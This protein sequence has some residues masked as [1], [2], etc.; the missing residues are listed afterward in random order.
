MGTICKMLENAGYDWLAIA[1]R[2]QPGFE[3]CD[4]TVVMPDDNATQ[5]GNIVF[6]QY[7]MVGMS[8][9][10]ESQLQDQIF[11]LE[12]LALFGQYTIWSAKPNVGKTLI[13]LSQLIDKLRQGDIEGSKVFYFDL[14]DNLRGFFE[15]L[16]IAEEFKFRIIGEG[17]RGFKVENFKRDIEKLCKA[18]QAQGVVLIFDTMKMF[19]DLMDKRSITNWNKMIRKFGAKGGT[20]IGLVHTNKKRGADGKLIHAGT[21]D[22]IDDVDCAYII[23]EVRVDHD[24]KIKIVEFEN[25]KDRGDVVKKATFQY[26]IEDGIGYAELLASV[27]R[28][29]PE[30]AE[31]ARQTQDIENDAP[32]IEAIEACIAEDIVTKMALRDEVNKRT[33]ISKTKVVVILDKYTGTDPE[34]YRWKVTTKAH[35][36]KVHEL[37][38]K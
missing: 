19:A 30:F 28:V 5:R 29:G 17:H 15:K 26:S 10:I 6:D 22:V 37:L 3:V 27:K 14:D 34:R 32:V 16:K 31:Q 11:V 38:P 12:D 2:A 9:E 33:G 1:D 36:Q 24:A 23:D 7:S 13:L 25:I 18:D 35:N 8:A 4:Y 20:A 21:S